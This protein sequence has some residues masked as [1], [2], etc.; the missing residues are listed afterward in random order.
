[1]T[2]TARRQIPTGRLKG[3]NLRRLRGKT[4]A[5][6]A[7]ILSLGLSAGVAIALTGGPAGAGAADHLDAPGLTPP[8]GDV[9]LDLTD[10]YAFRPRAGRT[11][12]ILNVN[13]FSKPGAQA[14]FATGIPS[15]AAT[16]RVS[17]NLRVDNNGDARQDVV[18]SVTFGKPNKQSVQK[19]QVRRN[20][21]VILNGKTSAFGRVVVNNGKGVRAFAGMRDDPFFFDL[22]GFLNIL[23]SEPGK[24]F[25]G[26]SAPRPDAFAGS[27]V[28]SIVLDLKSSLLTRSGSSK[29]GV[30]ATTNEG[31][32][33]IDRMGRPAIATVFIPNNPFEPAGSEPSLK[34]TYNHGAPSDDQAQF[35]G[36]VVDTLTLLYSLNDGAGDNKSDDAAKINALADVIL[37]D[38]LTFDT[39]S[40]AGF[41]NGRRPADDVIDAELPLV[42]EGA[43]TTDCVNSND[44]AFP[45]GFPYL[46]APHS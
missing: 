2:A 36:E 21:K 23:S 39:S 1:M 22:Q 41:L 11:A 7:T 25:L 46:A 35:R 38:I 17:Y 6:A 34:N 31:G 10:I 16:K 9:R 20:G 37:P 8:G 30:W 14:M 44:V 3:D 15:V 33:Q 12:L 26:C 42:T 5:V 32:A 13:G 29:I 27:N 28:S 43:V 4:V 40:A 24:S 45:G 19:L 18:L